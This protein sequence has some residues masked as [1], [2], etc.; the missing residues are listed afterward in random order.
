MTK[1]MFVGIFGTIMGFGMMVVSKQM[2]D[3]FAQ[4]IGS[5]LGTMV[6]ILSIPYCI[7]I[8]GDGM[9]KAAIKKARVK[10]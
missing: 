5:L 3:P 8:L 6:S 2:I 7:C 4:F 9:K 1:E 10:R